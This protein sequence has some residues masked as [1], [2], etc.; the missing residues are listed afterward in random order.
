MPYRIFFKIFILDSHFFNPKNGEFEKN[1]SRFK[2]HKEQIISLSE[3]ALIFFGKK[4]IFWWFL[5]YDF[6]KKIFFLGFFSHIVSKSSFMDSRNGYKS[7]INHSKY[8]APLWFF[9]QFFD[10]ILNKKPSKMWSVNGTMKE[11][12][13]VNAHSS[14]A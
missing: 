8:M 12:I 2:L 14:E 13:N 11:H 6:I 9:F 7:D 1:L 5:F 3:A 10:E 4:G